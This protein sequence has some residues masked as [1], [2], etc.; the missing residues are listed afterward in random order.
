MHEHGLA[1]DLWPQLRKIAERSGFVQVTRIDMIVGS[2]HGVAADFLAHSFEHA[3][4]GSSFA[5]ARVEITIA[6]PGQEFRAPGRSD[7]M[8][9]NGWELLITR[10]EGQKRQPGRLPE[11]S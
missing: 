6:D 5:G 10:I 4:A 2:L 3:F 8:T 11:E 7:R 1:R 9:A